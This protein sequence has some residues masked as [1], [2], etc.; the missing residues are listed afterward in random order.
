M[1][2]I[3][4]D[5]WCIQVFH[6]GAQVDVAS[7][8]AAVVA[9]VPSA[10]CSETDADAGWLT[11]ETLDDPTLVSAVHDTVRSMDADAVQHIVSRPTVAGLLAG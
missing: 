9:L 6:L 2:E 8:A 1:I 7:V 5:G 10:T 11:I 4:L 3:P